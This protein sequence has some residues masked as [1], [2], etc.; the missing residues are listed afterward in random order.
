MRN[1]SEHGIFE[2][3]EFLNEGIAGSVLLSGLILAGGVC[4]IYSIIKD[5]IDDNKDRKAIKQAFKIARENNKDIAE[6]DKQIK[7]IRVF[8]KEKFLEQ[9]FVKD[10][11]RYK[12]KSAP[13]AIYC[14]IDKDDKIIAYAIYDGKVRGCLFGTVGNSIKRDALEYLYALFEYKMGLKGENL[15]KF[16]KI[17]SFKHPYG[18]VWG[19]NGTPNASRPNYDNLTDDEKSKLNSDIEKL[20]SDFVSFAKSK[21]PGYEIDV[22]NDD[23]FDIGIHIFDKNDPAKRD[24]SAINWTAYDR[25]WASSGPQEFLDKAEEVFR[26]FCKKYNLLTGNSNSAMGTKDNYPYIVIERDDNPDDYLTADF[27]IRTSFS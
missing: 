15:K 26:A 18:F 2:S 19:G 20:S 25:Y 17:P 21:F 4:A 27:Y 1:K 24:G 6:L 9:D 22:D 11:D 3:V 7:H 12:L 23:A 5:T 8:N 10:E 14:A 16:C 13:V